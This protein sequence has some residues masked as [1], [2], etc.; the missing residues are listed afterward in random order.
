MATLSSVNYHILEPC[1]AK[2]TFCFATFRDV[3]GFLKEPEAFRLLD[4]IAAAGA[5]K[6][7]FA[8]GEPTLHPF[9]DRLI[10]RSKELGL[11]TSIVTNGAL[12]E[13]LLPRVAGALDW[14]CLSVDSADEGVQAALGRGDGTH[15]R[16]SL[17]RAA[18][19][20]DLGIRLKLNT[21]VTR[22][23]A[24]EDMT[25]YVRAFAPDRWKVFQVLP[26]R[27][28]ND[29]A[30]EPL[31]ISREEFEAFVRR[32]ERLASDRIVIVPED[33]D[34]MTDSYAMIDP[35]GRFFGN[36]GGEYVT[37]QPILAVG[38][39]EALKQ[40]GYAHERLI[41]RGG[42]YEWAAR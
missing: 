28:Q 10:V 31:L 14:V 37:S 19:C 41:D 33:N 35:L 23:N 6:I 11:T 1:D 25:D 30:V 42:E 18:M 13:R 21:V 36:S 34:A 20:R 24:T 17:R 9:V 4:M 27:G 22:L 2:C 16:K 32:H 3:R 8:G 39:N 7:N 12:L 38:V 40:S 15:V 5:R 29:G 26:V